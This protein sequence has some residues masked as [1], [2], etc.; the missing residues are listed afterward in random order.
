MEVVPKG[1]FPFLIHAVLPHLR[2]QSDLLSLLTSLLSQLVSLI[3]GE[4]R[5]PFVYCWWPLCVLLLV[6]R[7]PVVLGLFSSCSVT[8]LYGSGSTTGVSPPVS[9]PGLLLGVVHL[10]L[11]IPGHPDLVDLAFHSFCSWVLSVDLLSEVRLA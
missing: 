4:A 6:P 2:P 8:A 3:V 5:P 7:E 10:H 9:T 11:D 1:P